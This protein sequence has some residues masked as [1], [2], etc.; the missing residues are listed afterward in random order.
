MLSV[1]KAKRILNRS[2]TD[3]LL[4]E[5]ERRIDGV[6][7]YHASTNNTLDFCIYEDSIGKHNYS[8]GNSFRT[9][10][11]WTDSRDEIEA[12]RKE[13]VKKYRDAG[14]NAEYCSGECQEPVYGSYYTYWFKIDGFINKDEVSK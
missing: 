10:M 13:I 5:A 2:N 14:Y 1:Q 7:D 12:Y 9:I 6:I 3:K 11:L 8:F 4:A